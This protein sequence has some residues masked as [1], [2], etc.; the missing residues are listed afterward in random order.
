MDTER[1]QR[2]SAIFDEAAEAPLASRAALLDH[3]C[4]AD[5]ELRHEVEALLVAD[6][7]ADAFDSGV[8]SA[9]I[10]AASD[11]ADSKNVESLASGER[12][13]PWRVLREL[14][15][16]GMGV[17]LL[18]ERA[19]GQYEQQAAIKLI[20]RGMD[21]DAV[22][23][24]FLRERQI[25]A[26]LE[27]PHI[28][29]LL[30]GGIATDGR[31]YF[32][33]E[34][35]DGSPLLAYCAQHN[36][37][38]QMRIS[39][40][41]DICSAVQFAHGQLVVHRD[42]KPSNI[43]V[44]ASGSAKLLDFGIAKLLDDSLGAQINATV[45]AAQ[46][47]LTLAYAAPE[48]LRGESV[49]IT[50]DVYALGGV[51]YELL[52]G[53]RA[54]DLGDTP[55]L[56]DVQRV[57]AATAPALPSARAKADSPV[58]ANSLRGDLDMIVQAAMKRDPQRRYSTV[59]AFAADLRRYLVGRPIAARRDSSTYRISKFVARHRAGVAASV[60]GMLAL[61][62]ALGMAV[63]QARAKT[64]EAQASQEVTAFLVGLFAGSDPTHSGG[65][66]I[67]AQ[68]L[69]DQGAKRL[70]GKLEN[71]PMLRARLLNTVA[72]TY[73]ALGLYDRALPLAEQA[74]VLRRQNLPG[75][76]PE[77]ADSLDEL[78]QIYTQKADY[79]RAEPL[80]RQA[81]DLRRTQ[82]GDDDPATIDSFGN[83][84][85]LLQSRGDFQSADEMF[86]AALNAA[87]RRYGNDAVETARRL[88]D[89]ATNL[90]NLGKKTE[91]LAAY[92]RALEIREKKLGADDAEVATSLH[93]IGTLFDES[94]D[95]IAAQKP[96]ERALAIRLKV[97]GPE[98]PLVGFTDLA[99]AG[100]YQGLEQLDNSE[101]ST[102]E[103]L[104]IFRHTLAPDHPK[105]T[106]T[107][108]VLAILH[109]LRRDF[110]GAEPLARE[111]VERFR[112]TLGADHPNT[113]TAENNL[114]FVLRHTGQSSAA[115][116]LA[117]GVLERMHDDNGQGTIAV[118]CENL[119]SVLEQQG[120]FDEALLYSRQALQLL[121][122]TEGENSTNAIIA[123]RLLAL[124]EELQGDA[125]NAEQDFRTALSRAAQLPSGRTM[126][127]YLLQIPLADFLVGANRCAEAQPLLENALMQINKP[128]VTAGPIWGAEAQLLLGRCRAADHANQDGAALE[129]AARKQL[130]A[131]P[132]IEIDLYPATVK[133]LHAR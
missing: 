38:L 116:R 111:V 2:V 106:E 41:M 113:L 36:L 124:A 51:L 101:K 97:F 4:G 115:E 64:R 43:L 69:L 120:K 119:A 49:G 127:T 28:A 131:L 33:M 93:N 50:T 12:I 35:V 128:S 60:F 32:A 45:D 87:Q 130:R 122:K 133:L 10:A 8:D 105:I 77:L 110:F 83:L 108:N 52:T 98:H 13:G 59:E 26:R 109:S 27:H 80:L 44:T 74:L 66:A 132:A 129:N 76:D 103:A 30:D 79:A 95:D 18:A 75:N 42:I 92:R 39:I 6:A 88:D 89:E 81:L 24:R 72:T 55:T 57:L 29:R 117:R 15:R 85:S 19:D 37:S 121:T 47:P 56:D 86:L 90:D 67:S 107:L 3:L 112:R 71:A 31:P 62:A 99:L 21:S 68:D 73:T 17:V 34:Y 104:R 78:G 25:L 126:A 11:W 100:V 61:I 22:Q 63:W 65:A 96:L 70:Q 54:F 53:C 14:G 16:G 7:R 9:R 46:H 48:Q 5:V 40:F 82:L 1:W 94:G 20:K 123:L 125:K 23:T 102:T 58:A 118:D 84:G 91:A 114:S